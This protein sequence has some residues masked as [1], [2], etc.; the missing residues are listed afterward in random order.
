MV[1]SSA[2]GTIVAAVICNMEYKPEWSLQWRHSERDGVSNHRRLHC[3]LNCWFQCR[4]KQTL[5]LRVT[6]LCKGNSPLTGEFPAQKASDAENVSIWWRHHDSTYFMRRRQKN[7]STRTGSKLNHYIDV[8]MAT[9]A[10]K[11]TSLSVVYSTVYSDA[12][13]RKHQSSAS[14]AFVW[15]IHWDRWIP[16]TK[17][18]LRGKCFHLMTSP[19]AN[20]IMSEL[21][22]EL[23]CGFELMPG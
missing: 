17:G 3:L 5:K 19:C 7:I 2:F 11:I 15:G 16:R 6:G 14:L 4:S 1:S 8:I 21:L 12:D 18:Q 10:P 9:M 13:Q 22:R 23:E 20:I